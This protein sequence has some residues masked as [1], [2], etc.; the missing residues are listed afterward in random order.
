V[1]VPTE[2]APVELHEDAPSRLR[3]W[4][5]APE[6]GVAV[7]L[8]VLLVT[9][10]ALAPDRFATTENLRFLASDA[11]VLVIVAMATTFVILT[12]NLD[13]S[14]GSIT[15]FCEVVAV[16]AMVAVG[17]GGV[18]T[19]LTGLAV[20]ILA[21]CGWGLFN[22]L[23]I[24]RAG[25][26]SFIV[27]L[28]TLGIALGA[29]LLLTDGN[30]LA[31]VPSALVTDVGSGELAR[32]P[33][34]VLVAA[35]VFAIAALTLRRTRFGRHTYAIGSDEVAAHRAGIDVRS[36]LTRVYVLAGGTYGLA[37]FLSLSRFG[38]TSLGGH[39]NDA[40]N[41]IAAVALG[42]ASLF[43]GI[44]TAFGTLIGVFIPAVLE[45]GLVIN[46]VQPFWQ[47][48]GVGFALLAAVYGD[49]LRRRAQQ[50]P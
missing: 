4:L 23:L 45:N 18:W 13:L 38:T 24:T 14:I 11:S 33:I 7:A 30:D 2:T 22:G 46:S 17:G 43:G 42:G 12:A 40:L 29:A 3:R 28:A 39:N 20:A 15:A 49:Q 36:H 10:A 26:P 37:G 35:L 5:L 41:A 6:A 34:L 19:C 48:I 16:K 1:S 50:R 44:G 32:I 47:Q 27:T 31:D 21:G 9:F 8:L 25:I